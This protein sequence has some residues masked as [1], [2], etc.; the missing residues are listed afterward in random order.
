[1][2]GTLPHIP[3]F[4]MPQ[5]VFPS[6]SPYNHFASLPFLGFGSGMATTPFPSANMPFPGTAFLAS[7]PPNFPQ[8]H[9]PQAGPS[10]IQ[11]ITTIGNAGESRT[12]STLEIWAAKHK[13]DEDEIEGL[14]KLGFRPSELNSIFG[15]NEEVWK[16]AKIGPLSRARIEAAC[17]A[18]IT[19]DD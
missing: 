3:H 15:L 18:E 7:Q 4:M 10:V 5:H 19:S 9:V 14:K 8:P 6:P 11:P 13:L 2:Y 12:R 17:L 1:M 16:W